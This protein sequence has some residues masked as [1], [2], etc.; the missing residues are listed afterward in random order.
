M[1]IRLPIESY[2]HRSRPASPARLVNVMAEQK[3]EDAR[4]PVMLTR[5]PGV[6]SWA[7]VGPGPIEGMFSAH[8]LLY[9]VSGG[10]LYSVTSTPTATVRG[11]V[12]S[13]TEIDMD[14]NDT[15]L[16]VVSPPDAYHYTPGTTTFAQITDADFL[17]AGDVEFVDN[18]L[19]FREPSTGVFFGADLGSASSFDALNYATAEGHPDELV[20]MKVDHRQVLLFGAKTLEL[21]ENTGVAGFPFERMINGF[22][23]IGCIN[24]KTVAKGDNSVWWVADDYSVR[25]LEGVTPQRVSTHAI[26]QW[27]RT[28]SIVSLRGYFYSLEGH[29]HYV[30]TAPEGCFVYDVTT[31]L[32]HERATYD[33]TSW[34]W[35]N[36]VRFAGKVL[37]G[38]TTSNAIGELDPE[39]YT[40]LGETLRAEWTYQP[41]Y[42][43]GVRAFHDRLE[44]V[45][46]TGVGLTTGQGSDP[47]VMLEF[48]D[49]GGLN[50]F[51]MPN[52]SLGAIGKRR[53]RVAWKALGSCD[54]AHGRV[55]RVAVS[56]PVSVT[57]TD[58][59]LEVRGGRL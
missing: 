23:E 27:L 32:W 41:V 53:T 2:Q 37:V 15:S 11:A 10:A 29:F 54:S 25:R 34:D 50:W 9:V 1:Q 26:E 45:I 42:S 3:P 28:V 7:T 16:V 4:G 49:D 51:A 5:T 59:L 57:V 6:A 47:E 8:G 21:W 40:E 12:G 39:V 33:E 36:P 22:A 46:E 14:A 35:G 30:L 24:G 43:D 19:L 56:D 17:G 58:T 38:S 31:G 20:G 44:L 48:S 13:S 55:Y 52:Q 18:Y